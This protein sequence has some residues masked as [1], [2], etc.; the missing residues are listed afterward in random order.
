MTATS[1]QVG[2]RLENGRAGPPAPSCRKSLG[3]AHVPVEVTHS[4]SSQPVHT[5]PACWCGDLQTRIAP[6]LQA[7]ESSP[8]DRQ[9]C[10]APAPV[11]VKT[12]C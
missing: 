3:T 10:K 1:K 2:W 5:I 8:A 7:N 4:S 6:L 11:I 12:G 9:T